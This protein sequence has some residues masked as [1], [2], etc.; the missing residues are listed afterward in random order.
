MLAQAQGFAKDTPL[1]A[2]TRAQLAAK[3]AAAALETAAGEEREELE[4]LHAIA[5]SRVEKYETLLASWT[6]RVR[7][8]ADLFST[9][10][11]QRLANPIPPKL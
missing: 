7:E 1:E 11:K 10:E 8:R 9:H 5:I 4:N 2:L 3:E 6:M